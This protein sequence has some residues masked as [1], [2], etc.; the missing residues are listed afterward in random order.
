MDQ[1]C[2]RQ[3]SERTC[4]GGLFAAPGTFVAVPVAK[5]RSLATLLSLTPNTPANNHT[6]VS[7][8]HQSFIHGNG[9]RYGVI[10]RHKASAASNHDLGSHWY[11][12]TEEMIY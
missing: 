6:V 4:S 5:F 12:Q 8:S 10:K 11:G 9:L 2:R 3:G 1:K 7:G